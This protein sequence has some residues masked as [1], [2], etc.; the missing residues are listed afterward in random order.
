MFSGWPVIRENKE[1]RE[2]SGNI[3]IMMET[4]DISGSLTSVWKTQ[5]I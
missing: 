3:I 4:L 1:I 5:G 2:L